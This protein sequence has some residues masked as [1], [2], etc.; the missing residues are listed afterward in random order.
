MSESLNTLQNEYLQA[1]LS[2]SSIRA[3]QVVNKYLAT[4]HT[5]KELYLNIFQAV[6][7]LTGELWLDNKISVAQEH[8]VTAIIKRHMGEMHQKFHPAQVRNRKVVLG[9]VENESHSM[10][11]RMVRDFFEE[12]GWEVI[13]LGANVPMRAFVSIVQK[14]SP[15]IV[16]ISVQ[17]EQHLP[18]VLDLIKRMNKAGLELP[19]MVGGQPFTKYK[20]LEKTMPITFVGMDAQDAVNKANQIMEQMQ[21]HE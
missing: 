6:A 20:D 8:I 11:L 18:S 2:G 13:Y 21:A 14:T 15:D 7:H 3:K 17:M 19:I 10:G 5:A 12:D 16:G 4:G 1:A 9:C